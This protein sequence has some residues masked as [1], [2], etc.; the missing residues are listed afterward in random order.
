MSGLN[1]ILLAVG[2]FFFIV[3]ALVLIIVFARS[4][5]VTVGSV[6]IEINHDKE[7]LLQ[8]PVGGK[9][10][11]ALTAHKIFLS[12]ACGGVGTCCLCKVKVL[13]GGGDILPTELPQM[14][15]KEILE[16][17]R[18]SCQVPV[19]Q[20]LSI[21]IPPGVFS[22]R[23][24]ICTVRSN[25]NVASFIKELILELPAGESIDFR[26]GGYIQIEAPAHTAQYKDFQIEEYY[27]PEWDK[28]NMWQYVSQ[29]D[30]PVQ[31]AYSMANYPEEKGI[32]IL[33]IRIASPPPHRP[34]L[35]PGKVSS[36]T[37]N[38]KPGDKVT[39]NGPFGEFFAKDTAAEMIFIGG[40]A[41]MA[42]MRAHIF[43]QL[44][45]IK[46]RRKITFYYGA[47]SLKEMFYVEDFNKLQKEY[48]NFQW[49]AAL[50]EPQPEDNWQGPVGFIH[51]VVHDQYLKNH[52]APEDCE[53]Y[54]CGPPMMNTS[55]L[56]MLDDLGVEPGNIMMDNFGI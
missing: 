21:E 5:L 18:L 35:P 28:Y 8:V 23:Q 3:I 14:K 2:M 1:V 9:L 10:L 15:R 41:G 29:V 43:D 6:K 12:S 25:H 42:P 19:K 31:R 49:V 4:K 46:T 22:A 55:V 30:E 40:G 7:R 20:N 54:V 32:I 53:F 56:K 48:D 27:K 17:V 24:W 36:Y 16:K 26:A 33:N 52:P 11:S 34:D 44:K 38:L 51:Q 37:F 50:S 13:E 39:I 45:R 47:R